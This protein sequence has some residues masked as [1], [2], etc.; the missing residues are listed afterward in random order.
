M[1]ERAKCAGTFVEEQGEEM[2]SQVLQIRQVVDHPMSEY[3][4]LFG[5]FIPLN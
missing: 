5:S 3:A 4:K 2:R 1:S